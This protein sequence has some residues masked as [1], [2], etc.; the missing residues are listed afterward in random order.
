VTAAFLLLVAI[1][2]LL[3]IGEWLA[4]LRGSKPPKTS[5][6]EPV[7]LPADPTGHGNPAAALGAAALA[8]SLLKELSGQA[9][10]DRAQVRAELCDC[11]TARTPRGRQHVFLTAQEDRFRGIRRCC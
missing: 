3:S 9:D 10:V 4:L 7:W 6:T 2:V 1:I 11:T 8:L 5:E